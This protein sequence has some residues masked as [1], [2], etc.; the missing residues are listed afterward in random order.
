MKHARRNA[1]RPKPVLE[2]APLV[3]R[4]PPAQ[5]H[6]EFLVA[7]TDLKHDYGIPYSRGHLYRLIKANKFPRPKRIGAN[8]VVLSHRQIIDHLKQLESAA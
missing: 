2:P 6:D 8:R 1:R 3:E 7:L 5:R 4:V